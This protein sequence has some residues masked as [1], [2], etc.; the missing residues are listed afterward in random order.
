M[1]SVCSVCGSLSLA[2]LTSMS[3]EMFLY[4][5]VILDHLSRMYLWVVVAFESI[6]SDAQFFLLL[7]LSDVV[8][9]FSFCDW[10]SFECDISQFGC[11]LG[12]VFFFF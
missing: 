8:R 9:G 10:K 6:K 7:V 5:L 2:S 1:C 4:V 11:N 12:S 3:E